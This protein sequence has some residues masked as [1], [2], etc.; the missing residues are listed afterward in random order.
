MRGY[1]FLLF[2][3]IKSMLKSS[4]FYIWLLFL[5][6]LFLLIFSKIGGGER[7]VKV[8]L[9]D[10]V[11]NTISKEFGLKLSKNFD[12]L[13][14]VDQKSRKGLPTI[15]L[16]GDFLLKS[17]E[18]TKVNVLFPENYPQ[19]K[20]IYLK[21]S[22]YKTLA[23]LTAKHRLGINRVKQFV[24][25]K[26]KHEKLLEIPWGIRHTLPAIILMFILFNVLTKGVEKFFMYKDEG[27]I[28]RFSLAP[29]GAKGVLLFFV[30]YQVMLAMIS[31]TVIFVLGSLFFKLSL[32][33]NSVIYLYLIFF[34]FSILVSSFSLIV[35]S[36]VKK[37]EAAIAL[38]VMVANVLCALGGLWWPIEIVPPF[39]KKL[40]LILP[41]GF[42]MSLIDKVIYYKVP[43]T[44]ILGDFLIF[45]ILSLT[46]FAISLLIFIK[47][48]ARY[49]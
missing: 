34:V 6:M 11:K 16:S 18:K 49:F 26:E 14:P 23:E 15:E 4:S 13:T 33:F 28:E 29:Q 3:E 47:N 9:N 48:K 24:S 25:L 44:S 27:L 38:G 37:K 2:K 36:L 22:I 17:K 21:I 8:V 46:L 19:G 30:F 5:P 39:F 43:F 31:V 12:V 40:G 41:T 10:K 35:F 32:K 20:K 1:V 7:K 42:T 45:L